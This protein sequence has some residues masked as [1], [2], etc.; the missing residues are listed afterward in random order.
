MEILS[1]MMPTMPIF[2]ESH[3]LSM[4]TTPLQLSDNLLTDGKATLNIPPIPRLLVLREVQTKQRLLFK[5]KKTQLLIS[6]AIMMPPIT[7]TS[8]ATKLS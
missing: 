1:L 2:P 6:T 4:L 7:P 3:I 5:R 8:L